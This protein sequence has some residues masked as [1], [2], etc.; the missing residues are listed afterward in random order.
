MRGLAEIEGDPFKAEEAKRKLE[1]EIGPLEEEIRGRKSG[2]SGGISSVFKKS[3]D[4][5]NDSLY[6]KYL[7]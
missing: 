5:Q 1:R 3:T 7:L 2:K 6:A 4:G